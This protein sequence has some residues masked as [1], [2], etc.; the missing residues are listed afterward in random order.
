MAD[1]NAEPVRGDR[2]KNTVRHLKQQPGLGLLV[3]GVSLPRTW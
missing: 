1:W 3:P 2:L